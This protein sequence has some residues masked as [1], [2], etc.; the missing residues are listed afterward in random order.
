MVPSLNEVA[1]KY[2][3]DVYKMG[4]LRVYLHGECESHASKRTSML[5][6]TD[7]SM[8]LKKTTVSECTERPGRYTANA[9]S[10]VVGEVMWN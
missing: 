1:L 5:Q 4:K 7:Y 3:L 2:Y 9:V 10:V 8:A 6:H